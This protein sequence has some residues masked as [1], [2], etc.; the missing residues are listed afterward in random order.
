MASRTIIVLLLAFSITL[1]FDGVVRALQRSEATLEPEWAQR[2]EV[3]YIALVDKLEAVSK[4]VY[5]NT[6]TF[7]QRLDT[8]DARMAN[9]ASRL[10]NDEVGGTEGARVEISSLR[11]TTQLL[12]ALVSAMF[13]CVLSAI[14]GGIGSVIWYSKRARKTGDELQKQRK[15]NAVERAEIASALKMHQEAIAI[16]LKLH[17]AAVA[18]KLDSHDAAVTG[19]LST[20][21]EQTN[22]MSKEMERIAKADGV[23]EGRRQVLDEE[24]MKAA[25]GG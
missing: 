1:C 18:E 17:E 10:T 2:L 23:T 8:L 11:A 13:I 14:T 16:E 24:A 9:L 7:T 15:L 19:T 4:Q 6:G 12:V 22:G 21:V 25:Q 3:Q 5:L 20:L